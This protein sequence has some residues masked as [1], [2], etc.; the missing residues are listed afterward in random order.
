M[1]ALAAQR[2]L[3]RPVVAGFDIGS[4]IAQAAARR[5][6]EAVGA[7]V[8]TPAYPGIGD[9]PFTQAGAEHWYQHLHRLPLGPALLD[10]N[11]PAVEA[12]LRHWYAHWSAT[13]G[14]DAGPAFNALVD[15]YA[16]PGAMDASLAWYRQNQGY[17]AAEPVT[18]PTTVLWGDRD[19]TMPTAWADALGDWFTDH[20]LRLLPGTGHFVPREAPGAFAA[21]VAQRLG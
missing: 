3:E 14:L 4:R 5:E 19:P 10:G 18:V 11:R 15:R 6:P 9:R 17:A 12:Y 16:A 8:V 13:P 21:A 7:L 20:E 2:G 1:L